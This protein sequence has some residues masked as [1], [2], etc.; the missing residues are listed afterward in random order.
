MTTACAANTTVQAPEPAP[1]IAIV[2]SN[3]PRPDDSAG[4]NP[5]S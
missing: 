2:S 1:M 5:A 4:S 3:G